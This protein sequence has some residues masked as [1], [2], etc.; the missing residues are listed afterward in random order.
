MIDLM[1]QI[2]T[3]LLAYL[4][5]GDISRDATIENELNNCTSKQLELA[6]FAMNQGVSTTVVFMLLGEDLHE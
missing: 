4:C 2:K 1:N 5:D 3:N 6:T